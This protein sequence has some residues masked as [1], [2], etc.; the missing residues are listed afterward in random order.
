MAEGEPLG[1]VKREI[2]LSADLGRKLRK[3]VEEK[4]EDGLNALL[5]SQ[6][7]NQK[8]KDEIARQ[9]ELLTKGGGAGSL[10]A[11]ILNHEGSDSSGNREWNSF[12]EM[13]TELRA[14]KDP[15]DK[16]ALQ[17]IM[18][19]GLTDFKNHPANFEYRD[20]W[21]NGTSA[22]H[23]QINKIQENARKGIEQI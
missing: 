7:E 6:A 8:L 11:G 2:A 9:N 14:S 15:A 20:P 1:T 4:G 18:V 16:E 22:I 21:T 23:K 17:K 10:P 3:V 19:K 13:V 12:E 5:E